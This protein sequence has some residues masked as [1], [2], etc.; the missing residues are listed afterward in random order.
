MLQRLDFCGRLSDG[1]VVDVSMELFF[2]GWKS[3]NEKINQRAH[4]RT[5]AKVLSN[6]L[7]SG[8][9]FDSRW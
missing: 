9:S 8:H 1:F 3:Q 2:V 7:K 6:L 4:T 5:R